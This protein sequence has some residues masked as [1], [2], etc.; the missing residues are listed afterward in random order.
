MTSEDERQIAELTAKAQYLRTRAASIEN[1][2][3]NRWAN[4]PGT[5]ITGSAGRKRSG[6]AK[7]SERA[8][9]A[10]RN[11]YAK[12]KALIARA[13]KLE[14]RAQNIREAEAVA[15]HRESSKVDSAKERRDEQ[16]ALRA[17]KLEDRLFCGCYPTGWVWCDKAQ[18]RGGDYRTLAYMSY[19][20]LVLELKP[21]CPAQWN[22]MLEAEAAKLQA[23]RGQF[24]KTSTTGQGITLGE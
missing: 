7:R 5:Y 15:A 9:S 11:D 2:M 19:S 10:N 12:V 18:E 8:D 23:L 21:D 6:L 14:A 17:G 1:R 13:V 16:A 22:P 20:K 3:T 24:Y 4:A